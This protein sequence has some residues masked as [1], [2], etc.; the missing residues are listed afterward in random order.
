MEIVK[1]S[2][3]TGAVKKMLHVPTM[4]LYVI[5]EEPIATKESRNSI[6]EWIGQWQT[7]ICDVGAEHCDTNPFIKVYSNFWYFPEGSV[8]ILSEY[9]EGG[10]LQVHQL[11]CRIYSDRWILYRRMSLKRFVRPY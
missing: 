6:V 2:Q 7:K 3:N 9:C 11:V 4:K 5:E 1:R 8:S 10:S